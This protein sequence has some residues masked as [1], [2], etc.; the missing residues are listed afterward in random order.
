MR[1][2]QRR[3]DQVYSSS[4]AAAKRS[5]SRS[6]KTSYEWPPLSPWPLP[7]IF[8]TADVAA[9]A[10]ADFRAAAARSLG[11]GA[12]PEVEV[13]RACRQRQT[14]RGGGGNQLSLPPL[15]SSTPPP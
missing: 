3:P 6:P 14:D 8:L 2:R 11:C 13:V 9:V 4:R 7:P 10:M 5:V 1:Q 12:V 15:R